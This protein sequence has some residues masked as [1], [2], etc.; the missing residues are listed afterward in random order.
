MKRNHERTPLVI[1]ATVLLLSTGCVSSYKH[2][3]VSVVDSETHAPIPGVEVRTHYTEHGVLSRASRKVCTAYT[4]ADGRA[5]VLANYLDHE[6]TVLFGTARGLFGPSFSVGGTWLFMSERRERTLVAR[7]NDF[8]PTEPDIVIERDSEATIERRR[9]ES[10]RQSEETRKE[11]DRL[12]RESPDYW[13]SPTDPSWHVRRV[14]LQLVRMRWDGASQARLG[15]TEDEEAIRRLVLQHFAFARKKSV[16][17]IRWI[18]P[19]VVIV[20]ASWYSGVLAAGDHM[21]VLKRTES[22]WGIV[23]VYTLSVS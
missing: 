9:A 23:V 22:G 21:V 13:P 3:M 14:G 4:G 19:S 7:S 12:F 1:C 11:V 5:I 2:V 18:S 20:V 16:D 15:S 6:P 8:I 10:Q 17:G